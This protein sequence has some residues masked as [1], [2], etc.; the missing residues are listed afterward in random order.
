MKWV[1]MSERKPSV[2]G[3][4]FCRGK[5][6]YG[7]YHYYYE[8]TGFEFDNTVPVNKVSDDYLCWLDEIE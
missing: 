7:G 1:L 8:D 3:Y 5:S 2:E 6:N 4:Y